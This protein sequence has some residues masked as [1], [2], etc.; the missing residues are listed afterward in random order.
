CI[1][2]TPIRWGPDVLVNPYHEVGKAA[3]IQQLIHSYRVRGHLIAAT[4]PLEY[5]MRNHTDLAL[6]SYGLTL[7][8]LDR[9]LP[10]GGNQGYSHK[11]LRDLLGVLRD[12][13]TRNAGYEH[14][15]IDAPEERAWFQE[16]LEHPFAKP[17]REE[18]LRILGR[19]NAAEAFETF[20]QTKFVGQ[21]RFSLRSE[22]H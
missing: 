22:E 16:K 8:D 2:T 11:L 15:H 9:L 21:K 20:L 5:R 6:D 4:D 14:M 19:L 1:P 10:A 13:Y 3:R 12:A 17:P 7:W 18:Q